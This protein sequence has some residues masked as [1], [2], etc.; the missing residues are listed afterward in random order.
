MLD[1]PRSTSTFNDGM[2]R[3]EQFGI[4]VEDDVVLKLEGVEKCGRNFFIRCNV[5]NLSG[6]AWSLIATG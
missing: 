4:V 6:D 3:F 1:A 5:D 2:A